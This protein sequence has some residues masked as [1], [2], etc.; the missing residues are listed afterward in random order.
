MAPKAVS[1]DSTAVFVPKKKKKLSR[2][3]KSP[4]K[5][6][7]AKEAA[8]MA[9]VKMSVME[10]EAEYLTHDSVDEPIQESVPAPSTEVPQKRDDGIVPRRS[11]SE[12]EIVQFIR[13]NVPG[14]L[15]LRIAAPGGGLNNRNL[16][17]GSLVPKADAPAEL[18]NICDN[19]RHF[20]YGEGHTGPYFKAETVERPVHETY[21]V[22]GGARSERII[23][24]GGKRSARPVVHSLVGRMSPERVML[25]AAKTEAGHGIPGEDPSGQHS[26]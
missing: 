3:R 22:V 5:A 11:Q 12:Y 14:T 8:A 20:F 19:P 17:S 18:L 13:I 21:G 23:T 7:Q 4:S 9:N 15:M 26:A 1:A 6:N 25:D 2:T 24:D 10:D 16:R